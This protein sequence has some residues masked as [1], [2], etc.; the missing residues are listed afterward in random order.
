[1]RSAT[2]IAAARGASPTAPARRWRHRHRDAPGGRPAT[3]RALAAVIGAI[4]WEVL[5]MPGVIDQAAQ[6]P[7]G[8][9][10]TVTCS[11]A[12]GI[13]PTVDTAVELARRGFDA[14]PHLAA[15]QIP[16]T[17]A[18]ADLVQRLA[19]AGVT[20]V[21]VV[22]G[23]AAE[24]AGP[25]GDGLALLEAMAA[26]DHPFTRVGIPAHPEGH[27]RID[28]QRLWQALAAKQPHASYVVTQMCFDSAVIG[29]WVAAAR[30]RGIALPVYAGV[31]GAV[32]LPALLSVSR[33]IGI[34]DSLRF[35][36]GNRRAVGGLLRPGG[37]RPEP[38][39]RGLG[40]RVREGCQL[41]GVHVYTFNRVEPTVRRVQALR[42]RELDQ[43][44]Q[45][46]E[47]A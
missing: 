24:A 2:T 25:F 27:H 7:P 10:V 1:M 34:G 36:R 31:P 11:P 16:G 44:V 22:G 35:A 32:E 38:L 28:A 12:R 18:L 29:Q 20:D 14:V 17:G 3:R 26:L 46:S 19:A 30:R 21:F 45:E 43:A 6:L 33:R 8:S 4:R 13:E 5:P 47:P 42:R 37:Y 15:R 39:L 23:D 41:A 9:S 40:A